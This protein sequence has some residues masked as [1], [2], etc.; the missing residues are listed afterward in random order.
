MRMTGDDD[1]Q[2]TKRDKEFE[3]CRT[4]TVG[5]LLTPS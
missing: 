4:Y 3:E 5:E 2:R 1:A